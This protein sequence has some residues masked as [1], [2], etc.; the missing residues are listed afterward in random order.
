ML[1]TLLLFHSY[2]TILT[3]TMLPICFFSISY[4]QRCPLGKDLC[5][6]LSIALTKCRSF[7]QCFLDCRSLDRSLDHFAFLEF[8][9]VVLVLGSNLSDQLPAS[10]LSS[11]IASASLSG[12]RWNRGIGFGQE[13]FCFYIRITCR[14]IMSSAAFEILNWQ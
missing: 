11:Q 7:L 14:R 6:I 12:T 3:T 10:V 5:L 9:Q 2:I 4:H 8:G 13:S 1:N